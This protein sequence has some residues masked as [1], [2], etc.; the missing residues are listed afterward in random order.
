MH[1]K[2]ANT[3]HYNTLLGQET[4]GHLQGEVKLLSGMCVCVC[5]G[6]GEGGG[7]NHCYCNC[8]WDL[9]HRIVLAYT[10]PLPQVNRK[11]NYRNWASWAEGDQDK[12]WC[13]WKKWRDVLNWAWL[14]RAPLLP[15]G[16]WN[17]ADPHQGE[18]KLCFS[19]PSLLAA[20]VAAAGRDVKVW[21]LVGSSFFD[22]REALEIGE[23]N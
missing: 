20:W 19:S 16:S 7:K 3:G 15:P 9:H 18:H 4:Q 21:L 5:V 22:W 10:S 8:N 12:I 1:M 17:L 14:E 2:I 23:G 6:G 13:P 11:E